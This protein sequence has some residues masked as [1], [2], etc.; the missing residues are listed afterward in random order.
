MD[1]FVPLTP[2][3]GA[4]QAIAEAQ[5][6]LAAAGK[7]VSGPAFVTAF[8]GA[9]HNQPLDEILPPRAAG[10]IQTLTG[11]DAHT[12]TLLAYAL[13][14]LG[15]AVTEP[16]AGSNALTQREREVLKFVAAG[17]PNKTIGR[18]LG[19]QEGTVKLHLKNVYQK[20]GVANR[21]QAALVAQQVLS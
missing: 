12:I 1:T 11:A 9:K 15:F 8:H 17:L 20:I 2:L 3:S 13:R 19:I 10:L 14:G 18:T 16:Q 7:A 6:A 4:F 5:E 21:T